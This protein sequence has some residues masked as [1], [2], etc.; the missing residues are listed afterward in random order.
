MLLGCFIENEVELVVFAVSLLHK[1]ILF[2]ISETNSIITSKIEIQIIP[3]CCS[4]TMTKNLDRAI[5]SHHNAV[6]IVFIGICIYAVCSLICMQRY[7]QKTQKQRIF[8]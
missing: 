8:R 3:C 4:K 6:K 5:F 1:H 2:H 7:G